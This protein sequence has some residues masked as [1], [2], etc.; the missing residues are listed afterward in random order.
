MRKVRAAG[1]RS[2]HAFTIRARLFEI[3]ARHRGSLAATSQIE[4]L[5]G[6]WSETGARLSQ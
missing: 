5:D 2:K 4:P 3:E 1:A 6:G